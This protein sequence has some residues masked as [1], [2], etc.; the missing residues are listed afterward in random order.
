MVII[1]SFCLSVPQSRI[2][3]T[4]ENC[5]AAKPSWNKLLSICPEEVALINV[6]KQHRLNAL[7]LRVVDRE[8]HPFHRA[9]IQFARSFLRV[10]PVG[11][12]L[13]NVRFVIIAD[14]PPNEHSLL[15]VRLADDPRVDGELATDATRLRRVA[16]VLGDLFEVFAYWDMDR[17]PKTNARFGSENSA[18]G[19]QTPFEFVRRSLRMRCTEA[20][21]LLEQG[22]GHHSDDTD[23][24]KQS[25]ANPSLRIVVV[26][27]RKADRCREDRNQDV[28]RGCLEDQPSDA[29]GRTGNLH[30]R[31]RGAVYYGW[32]RAFLPRGNR[33]IRFALASS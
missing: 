4:Y 9:G 1:A 8:R 20:E 2:P 29:S 5:D 22:E 12:Q 27:A 18:Q 32:R 33:M 25:E 19:V 30:W 6:Q 16:D 31:G 21:E 7:P 26:R 10:I 15:S 11:N 23:R 28:V 17:Q 14:A 24:S 13:P 3:S